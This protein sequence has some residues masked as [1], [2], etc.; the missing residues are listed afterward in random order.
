[1]AAGGLSLYRENRLV[2]NRDI[3]LAPFKEG[4]E[5]IFIDRREPEKVVRH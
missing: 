1:M 3:P 2:R 5:N 4:I